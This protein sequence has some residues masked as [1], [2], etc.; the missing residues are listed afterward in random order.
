M[1]EES[2]PFSSKHRRGRKQYLIVFG[3]VDKYVAES[4]IPASA[5]LKLTPLV[6]HMRNVTGSTFNDVAAILTDVAG[7]AMILLHGCFKDLDHLKKVCDADPTEFM[8]AAMGEG[9]DDDEDD[10]GYSVFGVG[11]ELVSVTLDY[12]QVANGEMNKLHEFPNEWVKH[13]APLLLGNGEIKEVDSGHTGMLDRRVLDIR[14]FNWADARGLD[15]DK[16]DTLKH[17]YYSNVLLFNEE[18]LKSNPNA[19][20]TVYMRKDD[21]T[22]RP[23]LTA[24]K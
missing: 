2:N 1:T 16:F 15:I 11:K 4:S 5:S 17:A 12:Q 9:D 7:P 21:V 24:I 20:F 8:Q 23:K 22:E 13:K 3:D 14:I 6:E 18:L 19:P 10:R